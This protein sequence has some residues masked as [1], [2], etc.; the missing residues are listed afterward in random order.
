MMSNEQIKP[1]GCAFTSFA[2]GELERVRKEEAEI[3]SNIVY[4]SK[5]GE[6]E[7]RMWEIGKVMDELVKLGATHYNRINT[8]CFDSEYYADMLFITFTKDCVVI[9]L[10]GI[11][12]SYD[13]DNWQ[14]ELLTKVKEL[15]NE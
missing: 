1:S 9:S 8:L 15:I 2:Q 10:D 14:Q 4:V 6:N 3:L 11:M 7:R 5:M 12:I 13:T